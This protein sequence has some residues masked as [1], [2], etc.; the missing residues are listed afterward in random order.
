MNEQYI[1]FATYQLAKEKGF[2]IEVCRC[3]GF[4]ECICYNEAPT[5]SLLHK[6]LR[7]KHGI[8]ILVIPTVTSDWTF[9]TIRVIS[10]IDNDVISGL[11]SVSDLPPYQDVCG[12]DY[13][14]YEEAL[15]NGLLE[16][17]KLIG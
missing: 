7:E 14:T 13:S 11:K 4:P 15:E 5:Q 3:G 8:H 1:S 16:A 2:N 10:E 12:H 17:L 9:K 6:C